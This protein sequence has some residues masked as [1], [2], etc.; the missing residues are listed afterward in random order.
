MHAHNIRLR[1]TNPVIPIARMETIYFIDPLTPALNVAL[2]LV[3]DLINA[4]V[5][6]Q[7]LEGVE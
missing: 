3:S 2:I 4:C 5:T 6:K 1:R 7:P